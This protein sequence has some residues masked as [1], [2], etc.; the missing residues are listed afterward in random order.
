M[1]KKTKSK[2]IGHKTFH[3][4]SP[5]ENV[6]D[7]KAKSA[8]GV[9]ESICLDIVDLVLDIIE[10]RTKQVYEEFHKNIREIEDESK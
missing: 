1:R 5:L 10:V 3:Y 9:V 6:L 2:S 7:E 4:V 8:A